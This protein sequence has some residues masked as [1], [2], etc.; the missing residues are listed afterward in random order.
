[1]VSVRDV[2][3]SA[4]NNE[5]QPTSDACINFKGIQIPGDLK[6]DTLRS[7]ILNGRQ[8]IFAESILQRPFK[9][10]DVVARCTDGACA[11]YKWVGGHR[12]GT[13]SKWLTFC[14]I[15]LIYQSVVKL[16]PQVQ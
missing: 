10:S 11:I 3:I 16:R 8:T 1:M 7:H 9:G 12:A 14:D 6:S 15:L 5:K 4:L 13:S 2:R